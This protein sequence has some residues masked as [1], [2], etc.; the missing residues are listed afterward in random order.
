MPSMPIFQNQ[1]I[2]PVVFCKMMLMFVSLFISNSDPLFV[3]LVLSL[4]NILRCQ[5]QIKI[6]CLSLCSLMPQICVS[7]FSL[8]FTQSLILLCFFSFLIKCEVDVKYLEDYGYVM[9]FLFLRELMHK[10]IQIDR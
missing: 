4:S 10:G 6:Q 9:K 2:T 5:Y 3:I 7:L 1:N 8:L